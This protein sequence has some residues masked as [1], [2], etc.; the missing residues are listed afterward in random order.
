MK[1]LA[2]LLLSFAFALTG[3][4][5]ND[6]SC[7]PPTNLNVIV[8]ENVPDYEFKYKVTISW[9]NVE[10]AEGYYVYCLD[11]TYPL[12]LTNT[13]FYVAGS[14]NEGILDFQVATICSEGLSE[15]SE[16]IIAY[17]GDISC[18]APKNISVAI[19][20]N[21]PDFEYDYRVTFS[22]NPSP[23]ALYYRLF[24]NGNLYAETSETSIV[25]GLWETDKGTEVDLEIQTI[26]ASDFTEFLIFP[27][28]AGTATAPESTSTGKG[29]SAPENFTVTVEENVPGFGSFYKVTFSWD[30]VPGASLYKLYING[31]LYRETTSTIVEEGLSEAAS[32]IEMTCAVMTLCESELSEPLSFVVEP[33]TSIKENYNDKFAVYPNPVNDRLFIDTDEAIDEVSVYNILGVSVYSTKSLTGNGISVADLTKGIYF[34][35]IKTDKGEAVKR[36]IKK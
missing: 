7:Q 34:V 27:I 19:E 16:P 24:T 32:G 18:Q 13:C 11:G 25:D 31:N 17:I 23:S 6:R 29:C 1:K 22:W 21:V 30:P 3:F 9:D 20:E 5:N 28:Q 4:A 10:G 26:C 2:L 35:K 12:G 15:L 33:T 36:F 14:N 8:E